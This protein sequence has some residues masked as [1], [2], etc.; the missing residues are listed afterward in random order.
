M[1][2]AG[3]A[4]GINFCHDWTLPY[5][6]YLLQVVASVKSLTILIITISVRGHRAEANDPRRVKF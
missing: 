6:D 2:G 3:K 1:E 4:H 5:S